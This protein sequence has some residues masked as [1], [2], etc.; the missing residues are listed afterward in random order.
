MMTKRFLLI[1]LKINI[2][3]RY[4]LLNIGEEI[5][6]NDHLKLKDILIVIY[7]NSCIMKAY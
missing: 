6:E 7:L 1:K 5:K 2:I 4:V 3:K